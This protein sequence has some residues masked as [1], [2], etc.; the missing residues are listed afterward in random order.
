MRI[1][2]RPIEAGIFAGVV[3]LAY[4]GALARLIFG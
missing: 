2:R 4:A 1:S 3:A